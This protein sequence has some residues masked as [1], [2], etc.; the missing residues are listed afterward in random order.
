MLNVGLWELYQ[1][2]KI[3]DFEHFVLEV[4]PTVRE[5]EFVKY[6]AWSLSRHVEELSGEQ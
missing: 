5:I 6:L 2:T 1:R 3:S 4:W